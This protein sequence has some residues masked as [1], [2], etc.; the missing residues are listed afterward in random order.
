MDGDF[1]LY[2]TWYCGQPG[3]KLSISLPGFLCSREDLV[4]LMR[5]SFSLEQ[6]RSAK[7]VHDVI[8]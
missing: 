8:K 5:E 1:F 4:M 7:D 6:G 3:G 2:P